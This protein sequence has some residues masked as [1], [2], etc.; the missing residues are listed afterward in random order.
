MS[1]RQGFC[2]EVPNKK[3]II[4]KYAGEFLHFAQEIRAVIVNL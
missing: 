3:K 1:T 4:A 2:F